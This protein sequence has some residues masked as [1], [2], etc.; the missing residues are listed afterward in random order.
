MKRLKNVRVGKTQ[1]IN[2]S[3]EIRNGK[4]LMS[5]E[6]Y[7]DAFNSYNLLNQIGFETEKMGYDCDTGNITL[8]GKCPLFNESMEY[9]IYRMEVIL[10]NEGKPKVTI[11]TVDERNN[12]SN[13]I[14]NLVGVQELKCPTGKYS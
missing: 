7:C 14:G 10:D 6:A 4:L 2:K 13:Q 3:K 5:V 9:T 11:Q 1:N 12:M 8:Y